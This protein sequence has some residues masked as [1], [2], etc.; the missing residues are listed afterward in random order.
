MRRR[1]MV[2]L[3]LAAG[4]TLACGAGVRWERPGGTET[5]RRRDETDCAALANRDRSV[6][7][8]RS[9]SGS[10]TRRGQDGLELVTVRDF[11]S[12]AF[13]ECM[14]ARGYERVPG[15]PSS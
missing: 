10:S 11:D 1:V 9:M 2:A 15:R 7:V 3:V 6:P 12:G 13:D 4:G 8:P 14:K 5:E